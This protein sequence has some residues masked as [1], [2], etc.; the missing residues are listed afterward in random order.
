MQ[1]I[2]I[3]R[4]TLTEVVARKCLNVVRNAVVLFDKRLN[5]CQRN[6]VAHFEPQ[7]KKNIALN[8]LIRLSILARKIYNQNDFVQK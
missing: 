2:G 7:L 5:K 6:E 4:E 8:L 1:F 3:A